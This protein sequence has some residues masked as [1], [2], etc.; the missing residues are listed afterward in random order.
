M[1]ET[2]ARRCPQPM[3]LSGVDIHDMDNVHPNGHQHRGNGEN[4]SMKVYDPVAVAREP[5]PAHQV[6][7]AMAV[8]YDARVA[9][10]VVFRPACRSRVD[11]RNQ[12]PPLQPSR[13]PPGAS[14][15]NTG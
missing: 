11:R 2:R 7:P 5:V 9:R 4:R 8:V 13:N 10:L 15:K 1:P 14:R 3:L 12:G 6:L